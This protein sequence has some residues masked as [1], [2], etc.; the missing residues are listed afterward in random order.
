MSDEE[1]TYGLLEHYSN[2]IRIIKPNEILL[3]RLGNDT[4][5]VD[6]LEHLDR[7]QLRNLAK[8]YGINMSLNDVELIRLLKMRIRGIYDRKMRSQLFWFLCYGCFYLCL[9]SFSLL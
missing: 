8:T 4:F 1:A 6:V 3:V 5:H 7:T 9:Y 2:P